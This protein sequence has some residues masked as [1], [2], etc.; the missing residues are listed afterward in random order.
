MKDLL[1]ITKLYSGASNVVMLRPLE[2]KDLC[3]DITTRLASHEN[4]LTASI[5]VSMALYRAD[6]EMLAE[7]LHVGLRKTDD[8]DSDRPSRFYN[9]GALNNLAQ[10]W[11]CDS[12]WFVQQRDFDTGYNRKRSDQTRQESLDIANANANAVDIDALVDII[13]LEINESL[14]RLVNGHQKELR[15]DLDNIIGKA[16]VNEEWLV[17]QLEKDS[18]QA[19]HSAESATLAHLKEERGILMDKINA[20]KKRIKDIE[21]K[22]ITDALLD[23]ADG[24][25]DTIRLI[26]DVS[27]ITEVDIFID[28]FE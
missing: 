27:P 23:R 3:M 22:C 6:L 15:R 9:Y 12:R 19:E 13:L 5:T 25:E 17:K 28:T 11:N 26:K 4:P 20:S 7:S 14:A 8:K 21:R 2:R 18:V 16:K 24:D 10:A 1:K